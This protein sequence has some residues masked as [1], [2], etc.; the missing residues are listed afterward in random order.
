M[1]LPWLPVL[2]SSVLNVGYAFAIAPVAINSLALVLA[3]I[4]FHR[5]S[6][7]SY[8]HRPVPTAGHT[9]IVPVDPSF[10]PEDIDAAVE[11]FGETFDVSREDLDMLFRIAERHAFER[12]QQ[13]GK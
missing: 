4:L 12:R 11:E 7:H 6:G 13:Q 2:G 3:G 8:P 10:L 9:V 1:R 5:V